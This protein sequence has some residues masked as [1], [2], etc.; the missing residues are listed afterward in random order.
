MAKQIW[1]PLATVAKEE[2]RIPP[3]YKFEDI[4]QNTK[5][6]GRT[7]AQTDAR[8]DRV[9]PIYTLGER[10]PLATLAKAKRN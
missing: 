7:D 9:I 4:S 6:D 10:W 5:C 1:T 2:N 8:K 3:P